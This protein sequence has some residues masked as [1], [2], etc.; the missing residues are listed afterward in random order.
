METGDLVTESYLI[1]EERRKQRQ[2]E[3][4]KQQ[5]LNERESEISREL[6][7]RGW[8]NNDSR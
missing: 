4:R 8:F 6:G 1:A 5:K 7:I 3:Y 2:I